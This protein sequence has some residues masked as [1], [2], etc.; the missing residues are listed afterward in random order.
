M[1]VPSA[2]VDDRHAILAD[3]CKRRAQKGFTHEPADIV[4][5][6]DD[7]GVP[8]ATAK[9]PALVDALHAIL[10]GREKAQLA[11]RKTKG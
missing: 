5:A 6:L 10:Y 1:S 9:A 8:L 4:K 3:V 2:V 11:M 7:C